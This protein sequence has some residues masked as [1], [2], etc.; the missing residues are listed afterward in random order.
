MNTHPERWA[1]IYAVAPGGAVGGSVPCSRAPRRGIEGGENAV[2]SLP[3]LQTL[4]DRDSNTQPFNYESN[5]L[6][7]GHDYPL[8]CGTM[9]KTDQPTGNP[10]VDPISQS[11]PCSGDLFFAAPEQ[12]NNQAKLSSS[13]SDQ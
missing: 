10:H 12:T 6:P 5:S 13:N 1:S 9:Q 11:G 4:P 3:H 2:H 7:L 8:L